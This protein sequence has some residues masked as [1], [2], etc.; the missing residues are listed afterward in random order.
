MLN[1]NKIIL[2]LIIIITSL[3]FQPSSS[4][5]N[6]EETI[7]PSNCGKNI[8][9]SNPSREDCINQNSGENSENSENSQICCHLSAIYGI[10]EELSSCILLQ[11]NSET[12]INKIKEINKYATRVKLD[13]GLGKKFNSNCGNTKNKEPKNV[14]DCK[15]NEI[16]KEQQCCLIEIKWEKKKDNGTDHKFCHKF[17]KKLDINIIGEAVVAASTIDVDL[18]VNCDGVYLNNKIKNLFFVFI[19]FLFFN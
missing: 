10:D 4:S 1:K 16:S 19:I 8:T 9:K 2:L 17:D 6:T 13:C 14:D 11:N 15:D 18:K 7:P 3:L 12:R 5:Q